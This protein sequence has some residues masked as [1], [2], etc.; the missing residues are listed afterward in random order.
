[1]KPILERPGDPEEHAPAIKN[2]RRT[3]KRCCSTFVHKHTHIS[4]NKYMHAWIHLYICVC[5]YTCIHIYTYIYVYTYYLP[6]SFRTVMW[7]SRGKDF[8]CGIDL[9]AT[10]S[11]SEQ[12]C[13]NIRACMYTCVCISPY[14][15]IQKS[16]CIHLHTIKFNIT[17]RVRSPCFKFCSLLWLAAL[18]NFHYHRSNKQDVYRQERAYVPCLAR[19]LWFGSYIIIV[20]YFL[21]YYKLLLSLILVEI[22]CQ[23]DVMFSLSHY[24]NI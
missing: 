6:S 20:A 8:W 1:M 18:V 21:W 3:T 17:S 23:E 4:T 5:M 11:I 15:F 22:I 19:Y 16:R 12:T 13:I 2:H 24:I 14:T 9:P 7:T 10:P